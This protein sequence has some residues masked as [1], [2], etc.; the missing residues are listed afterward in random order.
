M[1][2]RSPS[3]GLLV[4]MVLIGP[5]STLLGFPVSTKFSM[6]ALSPKM[7]YLKPLI[8]SRLCTKASIRLSLFV[9]ETCRYWFQKAS[10]RIMASASFTS[11][12]FPL[13]SCFGS[14]SNAKSLIR[15]FLMTIHFC[16]QLASFISAIISSMV[17]THDESGSMVNSC[18]TRRFSTKLTSERLG[19]VSSHRFTW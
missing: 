18:F 1:R 14:S 15:V 4:S 6:S 12:A 10:S 13:K 8:C 7:M 17:S 11:R 5:I 9:S 19:I 3:T 2:V 16:I